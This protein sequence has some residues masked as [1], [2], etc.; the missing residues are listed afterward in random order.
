MPIGQM[1]QKFE[2]LCHSAYGFSVG[3]MLHRQNARRQN[4]MSPPDKPFFMYSIFCDGAVKKRSS[5]KPQVLLPQSGPP[6]NLLRQGKV[7]A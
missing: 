5:A 1:T 7:W 3:N 2:K 6:Q 4:E